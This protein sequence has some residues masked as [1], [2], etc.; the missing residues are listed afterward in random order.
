MKQR[1]LKELFSFIEMFTLWHF[2]GIEWITA[3]ARDILIQVFNSAAFSEFCSWMEI[4]LKRSSFQGNKTLCIRCLGGYKFLYLVLESFQV[5]PPKFFFQHWKRKSL[6]VNDERSRQVIRFWD[7]HTN[8]RNC[9]NSAQQYPRILQS[10]G[11]LQVPVW[12]Q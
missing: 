6:T 9:L 3:T 12:S 10:A 11:I 8:N 5:L 4:L 1:P 2:N 7:L